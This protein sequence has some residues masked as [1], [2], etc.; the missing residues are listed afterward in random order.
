MEIDVSH[1]VHKSQNLNMTRPASNFVSLASY[2]PNWRSRTLIEA[3]LSRGISS[4][5]EVTNEVTN[6]FWGLDE[7]DVEIMGLNPGAEKVQIDS[8]VVFQAIF[9]INGWA[10]EKSFDVSYLEEAETSLP[11]KLG[12]V[13]Q[14][15]FEKID[16][17]AYPR[18]VTLSNLLDG[19]KTKNS[20][21]PGQLIQEIEANGCY[22]YVNFPGFTRFDA[23]SINTVHALAAVGMYIKYA[24]NE[25]YWEWLDEDNPLYEFGWPIDKVPKFGWYSETGYPE[26][27]ELEAVDTLG[28]MF[29]DGI[30]T[31]GRL[32]WLRRASPAV[33]NKALVTN[34]VWKITQLG[35][36]IYLD[37]SRFVESHKICGNFDEEVIQKSLVDFSRPLL[38]GKKITIEMLQVPEL[39]L[40]GWPEAHMP[41]FEELALSTYPQPPSSK[42]T[43]RE[44]VTSSAPSQPEQLKEHTVSST[45]I[46]VLEAITSHDKAFLTKTIAGLLWFIQGKLTTNEHP[47]FDSQEKFIELLTTR[48]RAIPGANGKRKFK[49]IFAEAN[50]LIPALLMSQNTT[51]DTE[52]PTDRH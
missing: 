8:E 43:T 52:N 34:G 24:D 33:I 44:I 10:Y 25:E 41:N 26:N 21:H 48:L 51:I 19:N 50:A 40:Y 11:Y 20:P 32:L 2:L 13:M 49:A 3:I 18:L 38:D 27:R 7:L 45:D 47:D 30:F 12:W 23:T 28:S 39:C 46:F 6:H 15:D 17:V 5:D 9:L 36:S 29:K 14:P 22:R 31:I 16:Q 1:N 35:D 37:P 4:V 42:T